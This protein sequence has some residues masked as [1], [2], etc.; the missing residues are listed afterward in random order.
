MHALS[1]P[2]LIG[3]G[4]IG[5]WST[6]ALFTAMTG[7]MPP[8]LTTSICFAIGGCVIISPAIW[9]R[10]WAKLQPSLPAF[11]LGL[12]GP[13]GDTVIYFAALKLAPPAEANLIH[14]LWPLLIVLFATLLPGGRLRPAHLIGALM[15]LGALLLLVGGKLGSGTS[16]T[17]W[18]GYGLALL[19]AFVWASYSV[20]SRLVV[21]SSTESLGVTILVA[22]VLAYLLHRAFEAPYETWSS[23]NLIGLIGLG[24]GSQGLALISWDIGMKR[25][26]VS[27]LG[28]ASYST[29]VLSTVLLVLFGYAPAGWG[30]AA[31]CALIVC[32]AVIA[33]KG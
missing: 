28:V 29:P 2:T 16:D 15:G 7:T 6:L 25:G 4:A 3:L 21:S 13:F 32:G 8:L 26:D 1:R 5:I 22:S 33:R 18:L 11:L 19:G 12:Y 31:A 30:L 17:A 24:L 23:A 9:R 20:L 27:F 10:E 14:Y